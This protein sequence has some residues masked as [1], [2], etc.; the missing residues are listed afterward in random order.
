MDDSSNVEFDVYMESDAVALNKKANNE[1]LTPFTD[2]NDDDT[3]DS[4]TMDLVDDEP[5]KREF[6]IDHMFNL[7]PTLCTGLHYDTESWT[8]DDTKVSNASKWALEQLKQ[9]QSQQ[10]HQDQIQHQIQQQ[11]QN[12]TQLQTQLQTQQ[13]THQQI[14]QIQH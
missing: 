11:T 10:M 9:Q 2:R 1:K 13:Q 6:Y 5:E 12:Q 8:T 14:Q 4:D 3:I 7:Q